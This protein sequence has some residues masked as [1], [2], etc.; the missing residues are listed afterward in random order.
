M[1]KSYSR[2]SR[3]LAAVLGS[4][5][6]VALDQ[7]T[8]HLVLEN[9]KGNPPVVI[10]KD[11]FQLEYL[12]NRGAAFGLFQNQRFFF[13]VSV[14]IIS[15]IAVIF[16]LRVPMTRRFLPLRMCAV[17][18]MAGAWG[19]C[20]DRIM[21]NY[22]VDFLYFKLIDFPIFNVADIYVTV[23]TFTLAILICFYYKE[24]E[25]EGMFRR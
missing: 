9:L 4:A 23:S 19:N 25:F 16:Y 5:V 2:I 7:L 11:I 22:V 1:E 12:E 15:V 3:C 13:F 21:L 18:I 14:F 10:I 17:F 20:L 6:L 24:E 8:K